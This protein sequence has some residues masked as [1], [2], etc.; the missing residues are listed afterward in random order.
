M[1]PPSGVHDGLHAP[2]ARSTRRE[3]SESRR[4]IHSCLAGPDPVVNARRLPSGE[5][6]S[7]PEPDETL[8]PSGAATVNMTGLGAGAARGYQSHAARLTRTATAT[9]A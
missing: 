2:A 5:S 4:R 8:P 9:A 6:A 7:S 1:K 3:S